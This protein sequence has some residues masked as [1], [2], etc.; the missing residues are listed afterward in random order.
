MGSWGDGELGAGSSNKSK[1]GAEGEKQRDR[2]G[3]LKLSARRK[4]GPLVG[5]GFKKKSHIKEKI[6]E[7]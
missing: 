5:V 7:T 1:G 4:K 2:S 6:L 3:S